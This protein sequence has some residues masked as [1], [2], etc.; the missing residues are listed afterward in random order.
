MHMRKQKGT[1][2]RGHCYLSTPLLILFSLLCPIFSPFSWLLLAFG[3]D[4]RKHHP[5]RTL[6]GRCGATLLCLTLRA[7]E[8]ALQKGNRLGETLS[9]LSLTNYEVDPKGNLTP[10]PSLLCCL[11]VLW[12]TPASRPIL[13]HDLTRNAFFTVTFLLSCRWIP[14]VR[15]P[16]SIYG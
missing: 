16:A 6:H 8:E 1:D 4:D 12:E 9:L 7:H 13:D 3:G 5:W 14:C 15:I 11:L 2:T 10:E